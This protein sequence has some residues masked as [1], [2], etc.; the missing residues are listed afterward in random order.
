MPLSNRYQHPRGT[1][2]SLNTL[3][4]NNQILPGEVYLLT[5]QNRLA[6]GLSVNTYQLFEKVT[7]SNITLVIDGGG[8]AIEAGQE[9]QIPDIP[10]NCVI[11]GWTI[12]ADVSGSAVVTVSRA[13]YNNF[14]TFTAISGTQKPTLS[15]AQK[16]QNLALTT[17]T[18]A[19]DQGDVLRATVDSA[20]TVK[21]LSIGLR[22]LR[23]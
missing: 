14:P 6:V 13:T 20:T 15:N 18:T 10:Y 7:P 16:N 3:A 11:Q 19:L 2:A 9:V 23:T 21:R 12:T 22:V 8:V 4:S 5:D 17:W 1:L